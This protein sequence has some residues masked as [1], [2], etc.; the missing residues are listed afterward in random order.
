MKK[1]EL[2]RWADRYRLNSGLRYKFEKMS[3][4]RFSLYLVS[5]PLFFMKAVFYDLIQIFNL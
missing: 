2:G 4:F 3:A 1:E 5:H